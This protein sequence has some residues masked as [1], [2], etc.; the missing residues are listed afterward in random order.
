MNI[1]L[2]ALG[3]VMAWTV[4][5]LVV[6]WFLHGIAHG[7]DGGTDFDNLSSIAEMTEPLTAEQVEELKGIM[8]SCAHR[9]FRE[10]KGDPT[11]CLTDCPFGCHPACCGCRESGDHNPNLDCSHCTPCDLPP[12]P[13]GER[14]CDLTPERVDK[15][16]EE[17]G[18]SAMQRCLSCPDDTKC[19]L[20]SCLINARKGHHPICAYGCG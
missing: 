2:K 20:I 13:G 19:D 4:V 12:G 7:D 1:T 5:V 14:T 15:L 18:K 17:F 3:Y 6:G 16:L 9:C 10:C 8:E 11:L